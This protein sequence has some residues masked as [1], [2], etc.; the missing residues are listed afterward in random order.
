MNIYEQEEQAFLERFK[1]VSEGRKNILVSYSGGADSDIMLYLFKKSNLLDKVTFVFFDTGIEFR[2]TKE[3]IANKIFHEGLNITMIRS[4]KPVSLC[5]KQ[6]GQP[7]INKYVSEM[8]LRLQRHNFNFKDHGPLNY[9]QL[10]K[11]YP[12]CLVGIRW[13]SNY[14]GSIYDPNEKNKLDYGGTNRS[15]FNISRNKNLREYLIKNGLNFKVSSKCCTYAKKK[16]SHNFELKFKPDLIINGIRKSEG[17]IRARKYKR[18]FTINE[19][20]KPDLWLPLLHWKDDF[21]EQYKKYNNIKFSDCYEVY[22][23]KRTGCAGCPFSQNLQ[24]ERNILKKYEPNLSIAIENIFKD[25][26]KATE[27]YNIFNLWN[28]IK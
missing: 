12:R 19:T 18:C 24:Y 10:I 13:F 20:G 2:A 21:K 17:G 5:V 11:L 3:H 14:Y 28:S 6:Y 15:N 22:G 26:Y 4:F 25:T 23:L 7:F 27:D 16:T 8:L 9:E 1:Y